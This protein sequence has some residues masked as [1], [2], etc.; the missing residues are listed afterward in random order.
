[1][2]HCKN[3]RRTHIMVLSI[4]FSNLH[5]SKNKIKYVF[6]WANWGYF[7]VHLCL[8]CLYF[9]FLY[10]SLSVFWSLFSVSSYYCYRLA[11]LFSNNSFLSI[12]FVYIIC[13]KSCFNYLNSLHLFF[14]IILSEFNYILIKNEFY[15]S[16]NINKNKQRNLKR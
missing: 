5:N 16:K 9:N 14:F 10:L 1:M 3:V 2:Y 12:Q 8:V 13:F 15:E 11:Y 7:T 6:A 4:S